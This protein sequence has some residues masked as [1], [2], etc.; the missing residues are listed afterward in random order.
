MEGIVARTFPKLD[1]Q[2]GFSL[3]PKETQ[4]TKPQGVPHNFKFMYIFSEL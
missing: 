1:P 4:F 2:P 3:E